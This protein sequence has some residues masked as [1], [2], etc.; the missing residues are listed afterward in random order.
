MGYFFVELLRL[1]FIPSASQLKLLL[2]L[3]LADDIIRV[4]LDLLQNVVFVRLR[5]DFDCLVDHFA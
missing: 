4:D 5:L 2:F 3:K 1:I